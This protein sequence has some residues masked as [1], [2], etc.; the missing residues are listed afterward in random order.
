MPSTCNSQGRYVLTEKLLRVALLALYGVHSK[1]KSLEGKMEEY[2]A[3]DDPWA[4]A[5]PTL[6]SK[7]EI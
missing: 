1:R 4:I 2:D 6:R 7:E 5:C 3:G